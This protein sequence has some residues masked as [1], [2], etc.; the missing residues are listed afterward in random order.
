MKRLACLTLSGLKS[1]KDVT[2][3]GTHHLLGLRDS[4]QH[5]HGNIKQPD[6]QLDWQKCLVCRSKR[7]RTTESEAPVL[8]HPQV[9]K[10]AN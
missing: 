7:Y 5:G 2:T 10:L 8:L 4:R 3:R 9:L 6:G 1:L